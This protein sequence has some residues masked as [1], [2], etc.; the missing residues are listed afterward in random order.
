MGQGWNLLQWLGVSAASDT[1]RVV[2]DRVSDELEGLPESRARYVAAFAYLL[3]RVAGADLHT[4]DAEMAVMRRLVA[5]EGGLAAHEAEAVVT[6]ALKEHHTF[7]GTHNGAVSREFASVSTPD[8]RMGLLRCLYAVSSADDSITVKEDNEI[9]RITEELRL[10]HA[11]FV[12]A[13]QEVRQHLAVL[14][15]VPQGPPALSDTHRPRG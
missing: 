13:R 1:D 2:L 15:A 10:E 5:E 12:R 9:R 6:L 14:R 8:E 3:G 11:D 7:G 4:S